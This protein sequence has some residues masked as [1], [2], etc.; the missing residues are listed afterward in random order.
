M[1]GATQVSPGQSVWEPESA[2]EKVIYSGGG[3]SN[4]FGMPDYQKAAVEAYLEAY[5]IPYPNDIYNS[6]GKVCFRTVS[7][8]NIDDRSCYSLARFPTFLPTERTISLLS[9]AHLTMSMER[10]RLHP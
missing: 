8:R 1:V 9:M 3:F 7:L 4:Y 6:T 5:P 2:C 10:P